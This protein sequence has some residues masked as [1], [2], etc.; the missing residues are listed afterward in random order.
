M[1]SIAALGILIV[2]I[3]GALVSFAFWPS[4]FAFAFRNILRDMPEAKTLFMGSGSWIAFSRRFGLPYVLALLVISFI[5]LPVGMRLLPDTDVGGWLLF[6]PM[7]VSMSLGVALGALR[8]M[9]WM[10]DER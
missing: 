1:Q 8:I 9:R 6:G 3:I 10:V 7:L 4:L 5:W 2:L